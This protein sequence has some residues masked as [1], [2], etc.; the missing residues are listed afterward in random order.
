MNWEDIKGL[1]FYLLY[2]LLL[3]GFFVYSGMTGWKWYN[4]TPTESERPATSG[5]SGHIYRYHK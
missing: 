1:K 3:I 4:D 2:C 5:R